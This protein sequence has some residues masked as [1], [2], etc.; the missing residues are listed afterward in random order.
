MN[1]Y[2]F[3]FA[4]IVLN[5]VSAVVIHH[6]GNMIKLNVMIA[7]SSFYALIFFHLLNIGNIVSMYKKAFKNIK[8]CCLLV[9]IFAIMW[10]VCFL[11]PVYYTPA[12][13]M[14]YA[15][16]WPS[17]F[18][19]FFTYMKK[20]ESHSRITFLT[21]LTLIIGFYFVLDYEQEWS[22]MGLLVLLTTIAGITM[23]MYSKLS[24]SM[25]EVGFSPSEILAIRFVFLTIFSLIYILNNG[26]LFN[27]TANDLSYSLFV[28]MMS[29]IIPIYFSQISISKVGANN[30]SIV[31]GFTP[32]FCFG[33]EY[34]YFYFT[35][36]NSA[37]VHVDGY[38]SIALAVVLVMYGLTSRN[39][40]NKICLET[41]IK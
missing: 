17:L 34:I 26:E 29:L 22:S 39:L 33:F 12:I 15:T 25:N 41:N 19:L 14:F 28:S 16:A 1:T 10:W 31:M 6:V 13:L 32:F 36:N 8:L 27:I 40:E 5:A 37:M 3:T 23:Y 35:S 38:F 21:I 20:K 7:L 30:H 11:I 2:K 9:S 24:Q 18:G 4:Y